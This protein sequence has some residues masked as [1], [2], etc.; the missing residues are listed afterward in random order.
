LLEP[1]GSLSSVLVLHSSPNAISAR[2]K[3]QPCQSGDHREVGPLADVAAF[4]RS[5]KA[6][7][8]RRNRQ[9]F[10]GKIFVDGPCINDSQTSDQQ[11]GFYGIFT[12]RALCFVLSS[13][14]SSGPK[15]ASNRH[16]RVNFLRFVCRDS[17]RRTFR[18]RWLHRSCSESLEHVS[19]IV[20]RKILPHVSSVCK[21][22]FFQSEKGHCHVQVG[23]GEAFSGAREATIFSKR[24]SPRNGS[25]KGSSFSWP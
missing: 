22:Q 21:V 24:G 14:S 11:R 6:G 4:H 9:L 2:A 18:K 8:A 25:Q 5:S 16:P 19:P 17:L 1:C 7:S 20:L 23:Q 15:P 13:S 12:A 3:R 10:D